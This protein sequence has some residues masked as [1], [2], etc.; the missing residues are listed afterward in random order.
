M[1]NSLRIL[2]TAMPIWFAMTA[3]ADDSA[4]FLARLQSAAE[5]AIPPIQKAMTGSADQRECFTCHH[6]AVPVVALAAAESRGLAVERAGLDRQI[7]HTITHLQR[8]YE[9]YERGKG[10]GGQVATAGYALLALQAA[11]WPAD[12]TTDAVVHYLLQHQRRASHY[13]ENSN[14][15][16]TS[17][18]D[19]TATYLAAQGML[20]YG[21]ASQQSAIDKRIRTVS[22]WVMT[23]E[24]SDTE[25]AV[26]RLKL[27][28]LLDASP[29]HIDSARQQ[30]F[31]LQR[32][33]GGWAQ[34][35]EM[36]S[37]PYATATAV[38]AL[39]TATGVDGLDARIRK[40]L[41]YLLDTQQADGTWHVAT[42]A[43]GFQTYFESG[44]PY[45]EDQFISM[46]ATSWALLSLVESMSA[47]DSEALS[48]V[49]A[50]KD[51]P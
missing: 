36:D 23:S 20:S 40:G 6:Q 38:H 44:F 19:F 8:G 21:T 1:C 11:N 24:P 27:L 17:G 9:N 37:D 25:D 7:Q 41:L 3:A 14:R 43:D 49:S 45:E 2:L 28:L 32:D 46:S 33:D 10:Q 42:R 18:S 30:L 51:L 35:P 13:S 5:R 12:E 47:A 34:L 22:D 16:P 39:L 15:P 50:V 26:F 48:E 4:P 31:D 29:E